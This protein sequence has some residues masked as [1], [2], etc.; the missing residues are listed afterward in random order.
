MAFRTDWL[1][2]SAPFKAKITAS[3]QHLVIENGLI[4]R[5]FVLTP[6]AATISLRDEVT[7]EELLRA[8]KPEATVTVNG[9]ELSVGGL[10]GQPD[11]GYLNPAW[12]ATM[13]ADPAGLRY[14]GLTLGSTVAPFGYKPSGHFAAH[15]WPAPGRSC[16]LNFEG[17]GLKVQVHF[18]IYD[19]LP[20]IG[21]WLTIENASTATERIDSYK[22]EILGL[23]E[24]ES[25]G[26]S[27]GQFRKP[28]VTMLT[29][30]AFGGDSAVNAMKAITWVPD[31]GFST[32]VNYDRTQPTMM[33][34]KPPLGPGVD[35]GPGQTLT[36][37]RTYVL[38]Q[39]S[40]DRERT[41]LAFRRAYRVLAPWSQENPLMLHLTSTNPEVVR[42]AIDQAAN[43]GFELVIFSFGSGL[44]MENVSPANL[45]RFK[46]FADYAHSKG[47]M[48]GG[49]SLLASRHIDAAND[50]INPKT[51][52]PG[53]AIFGDSPCLGSEW[54]INYFKHLKTFLGETGFDLLEHDGS[55]PGDVC[56][57]TT[58]PGHRGLEDSQWTQFHQIAE[59]YHWCRGRGI[60]LNVPDW[61]FLEGSNKTGMGYREDNWSLPRAQQVVHGRQNLFDGTWE[62]TPSM[63]W[64]FV[65]L[66]QYHG[67]GEA[68]TI[69]P[70]DAHRDVYE[71]HLMNNLGYG[72]QACYRGP[73]L[74][75][76]EAT[77]DMVAGRVAWFKAHRA[78]LESDVIHL[79]RADGRDWDGVL[80]ANAALS[81]PGFA[82]V[83]N[84][85][86]EPIT[87]TIRFPLHYT[88]LTGKAEVSIDDHSPKRVS[89]DPDQTTEVKLTIPAGGWTTV[90]F[91]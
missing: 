28:N 84:P 72:A 33:V 18:E 79:R 49:Y 82:V 50:V 41:G 20:L 17:S 35:L 75:D 78:I 15:P 9:R 37:H 68:A 74:Y 57:S 30:Y 83:Y 10:L 51:G 7:G 5:E 55:Y 25:G 1:V 71:Q 36:S 56:A 45:A 65:P 27:N 73:R 64:M 26:G 67:G 6:T 11:L 47:L 59:F 63:G 2:D 89:L 58:H 61:Y 88:G 40:T 29:D 86:T 19:G 4:R 13:T 3:E 42:N 43:V 39:D 21:K 32:I 77:R 38:A 85:L 44:N 69:E 34:S 90:S 81:T 46:G 16:V 14:T 91:R 48:I 12:L 8:V 22:G 62:K 53:G 60:Y 24:G 66:V 31:P 52:K 70:L 80:H 76:T 54:G 23:V 87:R